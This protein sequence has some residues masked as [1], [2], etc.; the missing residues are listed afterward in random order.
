[1][2]RTLIVDD[3]KPVHVAIRSLLNWYELHSA[4]PVSSYNGREALNIM[5]RL[6]PHVVFVDMNMP[7]INGMDFLRI[8]ARNFPTCQFIVV[9]GYDDFIYAKAAIQ[10]GAVDYL[11]KPIDGD[12]LLR[13]FHKA[14]EK[15]PEQDYSIDSHTPLEVIAL[16]KEYLDRHYCE[17]INM[18][19]LSERFFFSK[20]Y[21]NKLFRNQY[22]CPLYEYVLKKRMD[23]AM[24]L[25]SIPQMQIQEIAERLGYSN[26]NYF[27]K[28]FKRRFNITP[29]EY[30]D[31]ILLSRQAGQRDAD[32]ASGYLTM[33]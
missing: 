13:A 1:M 14:I 5:E 17:D 15:L 3:E 7:L 9:S 22:H 25:L 30:R 24:R 8:A 21:L 2:Y 18:E 6:Q 12:E 23:T 19:E 20:E 28:A 4:V 29:T 27:G 10:Y 33:D 31:R 32:D 11:L 16:V 26:A